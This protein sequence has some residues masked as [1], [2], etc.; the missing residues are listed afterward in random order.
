MQTDETR[1]AGECRAGHE[2]T[3]GDGRSGAIVTDTVDL[4]AQLRRRRAA[5]RRLPVLDCGCGDPWHA[6]PLPPSPRN[7]QASRRAWWHLKELGLL[8]EDS[9]RVLAESVRGAAA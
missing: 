5:S 1:P 8:S 7:V 4:P 9:E 3:A 2:I 6:E